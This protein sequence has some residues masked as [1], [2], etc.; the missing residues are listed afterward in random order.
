M[1]KKVSSEEAELVA[2]K[3]GAVVQDIL[4]F[5][6]SDF[7][8]VECFGS[9]KAKVPSIAYIGANKRLGYPVI[10]RQRDNRVFLIKRTD[11]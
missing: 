8:C 1:I 6:E 3:R 2:P 11:A 4:D 10:V 9:S 5:I 7:D